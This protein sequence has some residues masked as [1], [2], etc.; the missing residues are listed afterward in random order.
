V[1]Q[2]D[3]VEEELPGGV[4][5]AGAVVRSGAVVLRPSNPHSDSIHRFLRHLRDSGFDGVPRPL[6]FDDAGRERLEFV[7]GEVPLPPYP[8]WARRDGALVS[9]TRLLR[10]FHEASRS[11]SAAT[12]PWSDELADPLGG[13]TVCHNDVCLQNVVFRRGEAVA[14]LDF[15][16]AAPGRPLFDLAQLARLCIPIDDDANAGRFGWEAVDGPARLRLVA[17]AYGLSGEQRRALYLIVEVS[18]D[19]GDEF[20]RRRVAAGDP[21]FIRAWQEMGGEKR[22]DRR[23]RWWR[24]SRDRFRAALA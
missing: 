8:E 10:R 13:P 20:V 16:F 19:R 3:S 23:L 4:A 12:M 2:T 7:P 1:G 21:N 15:D 11:F 5:N 17:D 14:L 18:I 22:I 24:S 9:V 6:G